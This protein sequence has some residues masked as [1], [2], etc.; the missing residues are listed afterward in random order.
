MNAIE[1]QAESW[2]DSYNLLL[3]NLE[4][5]RQNK[6]QMIK[7]KTE[8][9]GLGQ[10]N[11]LFMEEEYTASLSML[12]VKDFSNISKRT[13]TFLRLNFHMKMKTMCISSQ[14]EEARYLKIKKKESSWLKNESFCLKIKPY[15]TMS[16]C[17]TSLI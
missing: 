14:N 16:E 8:N 7:N 3:Q 2:D 6:K 9:K 13:M 10:K 11:G 5:E 17:M 1:G 4:K 15:V 12:L